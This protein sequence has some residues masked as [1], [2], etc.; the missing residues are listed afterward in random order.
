VRGAQPKGEAASAA[1][2]DVAAWNGLSLVTDLPAWCPGHLLPV[3]TRPAEAYSEDRNTV[4]HIEKEQTFDVRVTSTDDGS[5]LL[6]FRQ[7]WM[8]NAAWWSEYECLKDDKVVWRA[9][10]RDQTTAAAD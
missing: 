4:L 2:G 7:R 6:R 10:V 1:D 3:D 5:E 8:P 9:R